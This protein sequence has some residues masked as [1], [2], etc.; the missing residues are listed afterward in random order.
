PV[1]AAVDFEKRLN[2]CYNHS[3]THLLHA[4]L[5]EVLGDHVAQKGSLVSADVLRFDFAHFSKLTDEEIRQVE[6]IVNSRIREDLSVDIK[7]M[8]KDDAIGLGATALFGEKYGDKVR[9]VTMDTK[10]SIEL[11]GGTHVT[12]T[13]MSGVFTIVSEAAIA[14]GVRR[15]EALTGSAAL[16]YFADKISQS[17]QVTEL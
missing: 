9:V 10:F 11:C 8:S 1:I 13:G 4:A 17:K 7:E 5:K 14:S 2:T 6:K 3:A 15:I 16:R 12:K